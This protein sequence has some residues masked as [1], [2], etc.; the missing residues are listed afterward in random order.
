MKTL[1]TSSVNQLPHFLIKSIEKAFRILEILCEEGEMSLSRLSKKTDLKKSNVHRL[2]ATLIYL[3]YAKK[4]SATSLYSP[5]LKVFEIGNAILNRIEL[6]PIVRPFLQELGRKFHE[7][8]NLAVLDRWEVIC[9]DKVE[10]SES[11]RTDIK[12]GTRV[13]AYS[14]ASGKILL[15]NLTEPQMNDFLKHRKLVPL[16]KN[17]IRSLEQLRKV[18]TQIHVQGYGIDDEEFSE[19]IRCIAAPIK[20]SRGKV[21]A[22]ISIAGPSIRMTHEKLAQLKEPILNTAKEVSKKLG[23][24]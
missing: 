10:S 14:T 11:L 13:P 8:I 16:T 15:A 6:Q 9:I 22:A 19:G 24:Q 21:I 1:K 4:D 18:L 12:V 23:Y 3:G 17:T 20:N 5:T 7:T 2:L